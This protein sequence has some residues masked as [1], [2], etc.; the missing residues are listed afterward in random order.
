[1]SYCIATYNMPVLSLDYCSLSHRKPASV[2][3]IENSESLLWK[4][5]FELKWK[6]GLE[7]PDSSRLPTRY[8]VTAA[9]F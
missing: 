8:F 2:G 3:N 9:M 6:N 5:Q 4:G 1:M 7:L